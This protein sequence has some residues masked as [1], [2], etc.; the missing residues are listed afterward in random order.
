MSRPRSGHHKDANHDTLV[1]IWESRGLL[2]LSLVPCGRGWPVFVIRDEA[3][4]TALAEELT[5]S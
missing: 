5:H 1:E 2:V 4:A 3:G